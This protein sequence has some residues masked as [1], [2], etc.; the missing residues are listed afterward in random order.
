VLQRL[1]WAGKVRTATRSGTWRLRDAE[2]ARSGVQGLRVKV[3]RKVSYWLEYHTTDVATAK[4]RGTFPISGT[5]GLQIRL[6]TG[7]RS[8]QL[9][10]AA[11]GNPDSHLSFPDPDLV[12]ATLPVGS[13]F[14]TPQKVRITLVSQDSRTATVR[15]TFGRAAGVPDPPLLVAA[16]ATGGASAHQ[17]DLIVQRGAGD[18]GQVVLGYLATRY[19]GGETTFLPDPGGQHSRFTVDYDGKAAEQW[20]LRAVN[21]VGS[22]AES[23]KVDE[24]VPAPVLTITSPAA[25]AAVPGPTVHI[26]VDAKPDPLSGSPVDSMTICLDQDCAYDSEAPWAADVMTGDAAHTVR[27]TAYDADGNEGLASIPITVVPAPP[28]VQIATPAEGGVVPVGEAFSVSATPTPNPTSGL[29]IDHVE[30]SI[31]LAGSTTPYDYTEAYA[32][33]WTGTFVVDEP[34]SY[35]IE[36]VASDDWY[37][38]APAVVNVVAQ[39]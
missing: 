12:N 18:N 9:L 20:S 22:S 14:T 16:V 21:Q 24:H 39:P 27:V 25:G 30:F 31:Y 35:R 11:P 26:T 37:S 23:A 1:G 10:D 29:P 17:A 19:P 36:V 6:D 5:P 32:A 38:S 8:L 4:Q 15:V 33:P 13:S 7:K 2:A 34:G 28:T 3:S